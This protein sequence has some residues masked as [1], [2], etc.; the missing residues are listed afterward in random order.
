[1]SLIESCF[2]NCWKVSLV[3]PVFENVEEKSTANNF[4]HYALMTFLMMSSVALLSVL[5]I[6][7]STV[8]VNRHLI[9]SNN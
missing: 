3:A 8:S 6:L 1:M 9:C 4:S 7:L 5:M 2:P